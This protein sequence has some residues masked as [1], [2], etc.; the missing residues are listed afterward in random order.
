MTT[1]SAPSPE[2][3]KFW[4]HADEISAAFPDPSDLYAFALYL[5][6]KVSD[7]FTDQKTKLDTINL[8]AEKCY[9]VRNYDKAQAAA[10]RPFP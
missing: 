7:T 4:T 3:R 5:S 1:L 8:G 6:L 10:S 2:T 9:S